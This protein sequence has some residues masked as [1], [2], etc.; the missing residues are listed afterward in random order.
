MEQNIK[1]RN[2]L[3]LVPPIKFLQRYQGNYWGRIVFLINGVGI[4]NSHT[5]GVGSET[6]SINHTIQKL[7]EIGLSIE[8]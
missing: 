6:Q 2:R 3:L 7:T 1:S 4:L 5:M 8:T